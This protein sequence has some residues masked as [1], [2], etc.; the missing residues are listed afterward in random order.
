MNEKSFNMGAVYTNISICTNRTYNLTVDLQWYGFRN[1][2]FYSYLLSS[3]HKVNA[4]PCPPYFITGFCMNKGK[5]IPL[6]LSESKHAITTL[7]DIMQSWKEI[8]FRGLEIQKLEK[9]KA[10]KFRQPDGNSFYIPDASIRILT[11][12]SLVSFDIPRLY[13]K[14]GQ[15]ESEVFEFMR[16]SSKNLN[17]YLSFH[18]EIE[19][20][21]ESR[22]L[23]YKDDVKLFID[24]GKGKELIFSAFPTKVIPISSNVIEVRTSNFGEI[25]KKQK[26]GALSISNC[27]PK[28]IFYL[29]SRM[30][31]IKDSNLNIEGFN[32]QQKGIYTVIF[33]IAN[34]NV[35][36]N[37]YIANCEF[38]NGLPSVEEELFNNHSEAMNTVGWDRN[39]TTSRIHVFAQS[40]YDAYNIAAEEVEKS[41]DIISHFAKSSSPYIYYSTQQDLCAWERSDE[42]PQPKRNEYALIINDTYGGTI[43][44]DW[45]Q[46]KEPNILDNARIFDTIRKSSNTYEDLIFF[47]K[48]PNKNENEKQLKALMRSLRWL[49]RCWE[50]EDLV[51]KVIFASTALEFS[52]AGVEVDSFLAR[53]DTDFII[54]KA[55][56]ALKELNKPEYDK[57]TA[58][59]LKQ[60]VSQSLNETPL[61]A[62]VK[63][64]IQ[65]LKIPVTKEEMNTLKKVRSQ[66]NKVIHGGNED[67]ITVEEMEKVHMLIAK[68][69]SW[70]INILINIIRKV[71]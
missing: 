6:N 54:G 64:I 27:N 5:I 19:L 43:L 45:R 36:S 14:W 59:A 38:T 15:I 13:I 11:G 52:V 23:N 57:N 41:L 26:M 18:M 7:I 55:L 10:S 21:Q 63:Y 65:E 20:N 71:N 50:S 53:E 61:M 3:A 1:K 39:V 16:I 32:S 30:G 47:E 9:I 70:R 4:E 46:I 34:I 8:E 60:K 37:L 67:V 62:K 42:V 69:A 48:E 31:G 17:D 25:L 51:D 12:N 33:P 66:R 49:R 68:I 2:K 58:L 28:D 29:I 40:Y 22:S 35:D 56:D 24:Y 44:I